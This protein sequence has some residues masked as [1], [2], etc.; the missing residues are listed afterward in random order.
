MRYMCEATMH[1]STEGR[2]YRIG[3][4]YE[5][6]LETFQR[7]GAKRFRPLENPKSVPE[8]VRD[9]PEKAAKPDIIVPARGTKAK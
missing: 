6:T 4:V 1:D 5:L 8:P 2:F 9:E 3:D 7:L